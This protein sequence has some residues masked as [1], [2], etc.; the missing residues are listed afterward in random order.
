[1][2]D[3]VKRLI[4]LLGL[5]LLLSISL[6][7]ELVEIAPYGNEI[8]LIQ[9]NGQETILELS[10]GSFHRQSVTIDNQTWFSLSLDKA[11]LT[12]EQGLPQVPVMAGSVI[13]PGTAGMRMELIDSEYV[14]MEMRIAPSKGNLTRDID[15]STV[16]YTFAEFYNGTSVYPQKPA[17]LSEP[18]ILRDYRGITVRFKP[19]V[20]SPSTQTTRVYTRLRVKLSAEGTDLTNAITSPKTSYAAD[21]AGIY[22]NMFLNFAQAKYPS[23]SEE[24]RILVIKNSMFDTAIQPWV[25]WK[26]QNGYDVSVV[27][28]SVAG[29][30]ANQIK[31]FIQAQYDLNDGLMFV[32]I[33]GDAP[34]VPSLSSG[35]GGSD[36]SFALLAGNDS[37]PDIYVGRFSA[38]TVAEMETQILRTVEYE[39][40]IQS[41]ASWLNSAIGIASNEGG[42]SQGDMNESDQVHMDLIRTD[43]MG[44]GY[45]TVDQM[46]QNFGATSAQVATS[47]NTG[48]GLINY[49]GH[50]SDTSWVTT[51]FNNNNVNA[52]TNH[53]MLPFIVSVACVN[54]NFVSRTCFAE[55]WL[56]ATNNG[57][58]TGAIAMYASTVNQGW[59]PPMRGQDEINDLLVAEAKHTAGGLLFNGS[60]KMIE[61]YGTD[62]ISEYKNWTI[63]GDAS[64][65]VRTKQPTELFADYNPVLLIGM[66][67]INVLTEANARV[68]LSNAGVIYGRTIANAAGNAQLTLDI[69]PDQPMQLTLTITAPN[70]VTHLGTVEVL[71][72]DGAYIIVTGVQVQ[73]DNNNL[74]DFNET[75][76]VQVSMDNVGSDAAEGVN[77]TVTTADPYLTVISSGE[78]VADIAANSSG[79]T[80]SG[81]ELQISDTVPNQYQASYTVV[82]TLADESSYSY[83]YSMII[84]APQISWGFLQI[85]DTAGNGNSLMDPGESFLLS[86]PLE[87]TGNATTL[88]ITTAIIINGGDTI[89]T[90]IIETLPALAVGESASAIYQVSLSSLVT[91]GTTIQVTTMATYGNNTVLNTINII[92][93]VLLENFEGGLGNFPWNFSNGDWS[94]VNGGHNSS[95]AIRSAAISHNQTTSMSITMNNPVDGIISFWKKNSSEA[96]NDY[97]K[98]YIN[99]M[100]KGQ[101]SGEDENWIQISYM[102]M[103]GSNTYRWDYVKD[104][105]LSVG[106]DCV[107]IDHII[108]PAETI[109]TG[110][111][112]ILVD[113]TNLDFGNI[114]VGEEAALPIT[115]SNNG[116]AQM[117]GTIQ[118]A[119]PYTLDSNQEE[120]LGMMNYVLAPSEELILSIGF[121]PQAEG[122]Y[123]MNLIITSDD[124]DNP[125][126]NI[127]L[128]GS[129]TTVSNND[130]VNPVITALIGNYPNP[131]NPNTNISFSLKSQ[132]FVNLE[133][134]NILGQRVKNLV[135]ST[136]NP[137]IHTVY[138]NGKDNSGRAVASGVYFYKMQAGKYSSTKKMIL[139]K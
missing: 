135:S 21:F 25:D 49:V 91:P 67:Y 133:I 86:V 79:S 69:L 19:F 30:T 96:N 41:D 124:P 75:V 70:K 113:Q 31:S 81:I 23:L 116:E 34:Q 85:D 125:L 56:R 95:M 103:S 57:E 109:E 128:M 118:V 40:D 134:Y 119:A 88:P 51:G 114:S 61:V 102:V 29:P 12:L 94:L 78:L 105:S 33:M 9:S 68:T 32:Q 93:G 77:V 16:P 127:Q 112:A 110:R 73:D 99:G 122:V 13:I 64:L 131:F 58:P 3:I 43:L 48:R 121:R 66:D 59:N 39:R 2:E 107:Y 14:D 136:M 74:P 24:G 53:N 71:P 76:T 132:E 20:Y 126:L 11:G 8:R 137:G 92:S 47:V 120:T 10:L 28:V 1:M 108:F 60:S 129:A 89:I 101:W 52:L 117:I 62:G 72:A 138:W 100:L 54:G 106:D 55:A 111:P 50:G 22:R 7:A 42:G 80:V 17:E 82:V 4:I 6:K 27:D 84:N 65:M 18:F 35:G 139:M 46:Y 104:N 98:F 36:P 38:Q 115:I 83:D 90:P 37:Y 44:Y 97:L 15:P 26:R 63:F 45:T 5:I 87:N 130:I 123:P